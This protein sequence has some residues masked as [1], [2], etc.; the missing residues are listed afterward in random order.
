MG[1]TP[2]GRF[3][4]FGIRKS[5]VGMKYSHFRIPTSEL[6]MCPWPIGRGAR[7]PTWLGEFDSRRA[8]LEMRIFKTQNFVFPFQ[9]E[10]CFWISLGR[11]LGC[12]PSSCGFESRQGRLIIVRYANGLSGRSQKPV[13]V[14]SN[15]TR[16]TEQ[17]AECGLRNEE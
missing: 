16:T 9:I 14:S 10:I 11:E 17:N 8:L 15:L 3:F 6:N 13:T 2:T 5:E 12:L 1:S 7:L 4:E